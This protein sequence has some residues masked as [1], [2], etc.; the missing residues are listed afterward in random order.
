MRMWQSVCIKSPTDEQMQFLQSLPKRGKKLRWH[1]S[2]YGK[3]GGVQCYVDIA[4]DH[5]QFEELIERLLGWGELVPTRAYL[6]FDRE[7]VDTAEYLL[8]NLV[9][10]GYPQPESGFRY[11]EITYDLSDYCE[12]CGVGKKQK[13]PFRL[14]GE[15]KYRDEIFTAFWVHDAVFVR[16]R[17]WEAVFAPRGFRCLPVLKTGGQ[18]L[19]SVVQVVIEEEVGL[20]TTGLY[21]KQCWE[22]G[23][24]KFLEIP[25]REGRFP[26]VKLP[27]LVERPSSGLAYTREWFG[28]GQEAY[29]LVVVSQEI[30]RAMKEAKVE[31]A[32]GSPLPVRFE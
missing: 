22:C 20:D 25:E 27:V 6:D 24:V 19:Q 26:E 3:W 7:E 9:E 4:Q 32:G 16:P 21:G 30:Y 8:L 17:V 31:G 23:R 1:C 14:V 28:T 11:R 12:L 13:A 29:R 15:P 18:Q 5:P 10:H 2:D